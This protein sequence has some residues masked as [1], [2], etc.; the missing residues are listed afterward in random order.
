MKPIEIIKAVRSSGADIWTTDM[1][2]IVQPL[3]VVDEEIRTHIRDNRIGV[4]A[5]LNSRLLTLIDLT[6]KKAW[7]LYEQQINISEVPGVMGDKTGLADCSAIELDGWAC[8]LALR[9]VQTRKQIPKGWD[10]VAN[11][12]HCGPVWSQ[13]NLETLSCGWCWMRTEG[14]PFPQP[15]NDGKSA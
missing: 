15:E 13:H 1:K 4:L 10:Q 12:K 2:I 8:A 14:K 7:E 5:V 11:C 9:T 6:I 3:S